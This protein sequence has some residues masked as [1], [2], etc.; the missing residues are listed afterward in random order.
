MFLNTLTSLKSGCI[1][2]LNVSQKY[3]QL[4]FSFLVI[5]KIRVQLTS[6][7]I[8]DQMNHGNYIVICLPDVTP[9]LSAM[10]ILMSTVLPTLAHIVPGT[11]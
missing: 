7:A 9:R 11:L 2:Q 8:L 6:N 5:C 10:S 3:H 4:C 1:I